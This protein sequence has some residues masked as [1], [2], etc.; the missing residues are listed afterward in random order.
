MIGMM[1]GLP[2][3]E[4]RQAR[5]FWACLFFI[6]FIFDNIKRVNAK[7][8]SMLKRRIKNVRYL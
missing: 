8:R 4:G 5:C 6:F 1:T 3:A 2:A 7:S